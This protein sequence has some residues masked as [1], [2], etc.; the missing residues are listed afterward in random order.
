MFGLCVDWNSV[1]MKSTGPIVYV[2]SHLTADGQ[3]E[4]HFAGK[5][6]TFFSFDFNWKR[7]VILCINQSRAQKF[8]HIKPE[9][10]ARSTF[11]N[12]K[13][14]SPDL[15]I[16]TT[17]HFLSRQLLHEVRFFLLITHCPLFL[18]SPNALKLLYVRPKKDCKKRNENDII[19]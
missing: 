15:D 13:N 3:K 17:M 5:S 1:S 7:L 14:Y 16:P 19:S 2:F 6:I 18:H 12:H 9:S 11:W 10:K 4:D 8:D